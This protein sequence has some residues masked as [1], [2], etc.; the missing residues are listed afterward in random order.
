MVDIPNP[1]SES[2]NMEATYCRLQRLSVG[3]QKPT[4]VSPSESQVN[5]AAGSDL[6]QMYQ[7]QWATMHHLAEQNSAAAQ[8]RLFLLVFSC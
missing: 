3:E 1:E 4:Q 8:V 5:L 2:E 7:T 6:L